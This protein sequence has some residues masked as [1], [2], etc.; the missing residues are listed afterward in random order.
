MLDPGDRAGRRGVSRRC[1]MSP[2][3]N[4]WPR[5]GL[6]RA[7]SPTARRSRVSHARVRRRQTEASREIR[8]ADL[9]G[10]SA[11]LVR[12]GDPLSRRP[13][14]LHKL[15]IERRE[16][17]WRAD[18]GP[19]TLEALARHEP[20]RHP[21]TPQRQQAEGDAARQLTKK[22]RV[23]QTDVP[24]NELRVAFGAQHAVTKRKVTINV[25]RWIGHHYEMNARRKRIPR[26]RLRARK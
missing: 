5:P 16:I 21:I 10:S 8:A 20:A 22:C 13:R 2:D 18:I 19:R 14:R 26:H 15:R 23:V 9:K 3:A 24:I 17:G 25:V 12:G 7:R 4:Q 1:P 11:R 6:W